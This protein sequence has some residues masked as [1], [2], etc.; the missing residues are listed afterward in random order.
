MKRIV[1]VHADANGVPYSHNGYDAWCG[2]KEYGYDV[3][4]YTLDEIDSLPLAR[5]VI[6]VGGIPQIKRALERIG[7]PQPPELNVPEALLTFAGRRIWETTLAEA[8]KPQNWPIFVKPLLKG[9]L[10]TGH[11]I[12]D[13]PDIIGSAAIPG[14]TPVLAQETRR[15]VSEWRVYVKYGSIVGIG[16]YSGEALIF[17]DPGIIQACI[18]VWTAAPAAYGIDFGITQEGK[19]FLVEVNDARSLGNYGLHPTIYARLLEARWDEMAFAEH[20]P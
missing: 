4:F 18:D 15:F 1:Y 17:P 13:F 19:T 2:F 14:E 9:K 7:A 8:R 11:V 3:R 6:V 16:H 10:F 12:A 20:S 5:D